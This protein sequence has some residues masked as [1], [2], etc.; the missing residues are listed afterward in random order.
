MTA[1]GAPVPAAMMEIAV[2]TASRSAVTMDHTLLLLSVLMVVPVM[3]EL[4]MLHSANVPR[5]GQDSSA[6]LVSLAWE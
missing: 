1:L 4:G 2:R 5:A 3:M 6:K